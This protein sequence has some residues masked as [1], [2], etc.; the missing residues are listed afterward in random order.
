MTQEKILFQT[1]MKYL[2]IINYTSESKLRETYRIYYQRKYY[3][4]IIILYGNTYG[5]DT[6]KIKITYNTPFRSIIE[7]GFLEYFEKLRKSDF[8]KLKSLQ[9]TILIRKISVYRTVSHW[10]TIE[11]N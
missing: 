7:Y 4:I 2:R 1:E 8:K 9:R 3:N 11:S 6:K 5:I 10:I